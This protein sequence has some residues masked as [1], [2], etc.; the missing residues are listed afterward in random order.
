MLIVAVSIT[1]NENRELIMDFELRIPKQPIINNI[2]AG[3]SA[4]V[5]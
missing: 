1:S 5:L 2:I 4:S 3:S